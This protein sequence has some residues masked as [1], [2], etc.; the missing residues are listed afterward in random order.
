MPTE[1]IRWPGVLLDSKLSFKHHTATWCGKELK[2]A[3]HMKRLSPVFR[4]AA[5]GPLVKAVDACVVPVATVGADV[6]GLRKT[7]PAVKG[8]V[9]NS[10]RKQ[11]A[12]I[13]KVIHVALRAALPAWKTT[14]NAI[15]HREG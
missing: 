1:H 5:P 4:G 3:Q 15:L 12:L 14:P 10:T 6:W 8:I 2:V 13:D 11:C 9:S 7:R